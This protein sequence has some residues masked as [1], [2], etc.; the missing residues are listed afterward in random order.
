MDRRFCPRCG[1]GSVRREHVIKGETVATHLVCG[2]CEF[3]WPDPDETA[4]P[5]E[6]VQNG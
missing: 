6:E 4:P 2:L 1:D 5:E 3:A